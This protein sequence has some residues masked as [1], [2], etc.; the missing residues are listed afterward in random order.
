M[1][2]PKCNHPDAYLGFNTIE[3]PNFGCEH[4]KF[5][6][7]KICICCG[8]EDHGEGVAC[9]QEKKEDAGSAGKEAEGLS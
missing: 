6:V 9:P 5:R 1:R 3:C 8:A 7:K 4:Y 2:C